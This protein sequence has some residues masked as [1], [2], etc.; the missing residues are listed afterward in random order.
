MVVDYFLKIDG[1]PGEATDFKHKGEIQLDSFS[2]GAS[3]A[4]NIGSSAGGG[5]GAGKVSIQDLNFVTKTSKAS[6]TLFLNCCTG[7]HLKSAILYCRKSGE[8]PQEFLQITLTDCI[9]SSFQSGGHD[10]AP[11]E[12]IS[13]NF[14]KIEVEY[15]EQKADGSLGSPVKVGYD[16][17]QNTK[18]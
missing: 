7:A 8:K 17:K 9:V 5:G 11:L 10:A 18:V 1:V 15:K 3:N 12:S 6:P 16:L 13:L 2:W 4:S 14:G